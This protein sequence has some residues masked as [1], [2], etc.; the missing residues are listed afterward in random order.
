MLVIEW[1]CVGCRGILVMVWF[2]I[3][4]SFVVEIEVLFNE[5]GDFVE[6]FELVW[7]GVCLLVILFVVVSVWF[8]E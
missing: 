6:V 4:G 2:N 1:V 8:G 3:D 7:I 5:K